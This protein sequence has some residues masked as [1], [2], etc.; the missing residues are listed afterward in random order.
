MVEDPATAGQ[1]ALIVS[2]G[3][4]NA[5]EHA[6][7]QQNKLN[8]DRRPVLRFDVFGDAAEDHSAFLSVAKSPSSS[9][10]EL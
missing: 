10:R 2:V 7:H 9:A 6:T 3:H 5:Q 1:P 4:L 8:P